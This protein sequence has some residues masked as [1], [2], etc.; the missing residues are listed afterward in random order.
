MKPTTAELEILSVL[1]EHGHATVKEVHAVINKQK[2]T[3]YT[4]V[5]KQMQI[6]HE[7]GLVRRNELNKAHIYI[8][9]V[10]KKETQKNIVTDMLERVFRGSASQLVQHV[11]DAKHA[12]PED[13]K[14]IRKMI[15]QA[16]KEKTAKE[17]SK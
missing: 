5:L 10:A 14:E 2:P 3:A 1:W 7:K 13:L 4:T 16:E 11:L 9:T 8:P 15:R 6:M 17:K 12:S